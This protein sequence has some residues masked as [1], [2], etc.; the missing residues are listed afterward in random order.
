MSVVARCLV[1]QPDQA[2]EEFGR[3][4]NRMQAVGLTNAYLLLSV[5]PGGWQNSNQSP[6]I[7]IELQSNK[8]LMLRSALGRLDEGCAAGSFA[9]LYIGQLL[10]GRQNCNCT[11][12]YDNS[13]K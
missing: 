5:M 4:F 9:N 3:L 11:S 6:V 1:Q 2:V 8:K 12:A 13:Y 10:E 7:T